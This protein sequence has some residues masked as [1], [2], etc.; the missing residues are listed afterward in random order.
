MEPINSVFGF[1]SK[2]VVDAF[3]PKGEDSVTEPPPAITTEQED[4]A[5]AD[6]SEAEARR[7][8]RG[9]LRRVYTTPGANFV[10]QSNIGRNTLTGA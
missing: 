8:R 6:E 2:G 9:V 3:V 1:G 7:R 10:N 5:V 4:K